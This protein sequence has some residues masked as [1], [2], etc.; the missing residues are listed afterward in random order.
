MAVIPVTSSMCLGP[1]AHETPDGPRPWT[2]IPKAEALANLA[3]QKVYL[4]AEPPI[5]DL[6]DVWLP[7]SRALVYP[8]A[9]RATAGKAARQR[10]GCSEDSIRSECLLIHAQLVKLVE[11]RPEDEE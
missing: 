8:N 10:K 1:G 7:W 2:V 9:T 4:E 3:E 5:K 6:L 11:A